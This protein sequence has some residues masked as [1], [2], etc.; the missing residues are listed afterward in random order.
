ME[1]LREKE[2]RDTEN[3]WRHNGWKSSKLDDY[4]STD[5]RIWK[6]MPIKKKKKKKQKKKSKKK[7]KKKNRRKLF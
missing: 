4:K 6:K 2:K 7:K 5:T 1:S 3:I